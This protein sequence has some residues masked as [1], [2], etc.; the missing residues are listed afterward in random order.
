MKNFKVLL[1]VAVASLFAGCNDAIDITQ[2]SELL[3]ID[4][5]ETVEDL[6]LGLNGAYAAIPG[7]N[8][9]K[10]TSLFTD[11]VKLGVSNGGQGTDGELAFVL[12]NTSGDAASIW[13]SNYYLINLSNRIIAGAQNVVPNDEIDGEDTDRYNTILAQAYFL[14]AF[15]HFQLMSFFSE[16]MTNDSALGV[17]LMDFVPTTKVQLPRNTNAEIFALIDSDLTFAEANLNDGIAGG[18][19]ANKTGASK[20]AIKALRARMALYRGQ[21]DLALSY[22]NQIG[23]PG[24]LTLATKGTTLT[25][26]QYVAMFLDTNVNEIIW[27]LERTVDSDAT[28]NFYQ[29][30]ASV[31]STTTG[32]PFFEVSTALFNQL[33]ASDIRRQ[34]V[35]DPSAAPSYTIRPVGKYSKSE[36]QNLLGDIKIFRNSEMV[37]IAA[38]AYANNNDF[39]NVAAMVNRI[40]SVRFGNT[41]GNIAVP[42]TSEEAWRAILNERRIEFAFEGHR[43]L[44]IKRIGAKAG[45]NVD[46]VASDYVTV[47]GLIDLPVDDYR[48]RLPIPR[49]EQ[50]ANPNIQQN[51]GYGVATP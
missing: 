26:S 39:T 19:F 35:I 3:P 31:N 4:T 18:M 2:P 42:T 7:E 40:R 13:L 17:I 11:E 47:G 38:E 34:V 32:S 43:Y 29:I 44:D 46:R 22:V 20:A 45:V 24:S 28:G 36:S 23:V 15:G 6:K 25:N 8:I 1:F 16:D 33:A 10:F 9:I 41:S 49:D 51:P 12:N 48:W 5:Y 30:W 21:Y 37:L 50:A 27:K 14:R